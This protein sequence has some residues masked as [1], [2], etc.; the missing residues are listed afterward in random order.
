[1]ESLPY[2]IFFFLGAIVASFAAVVAERLYTGESWL[3][4]RSR[5][6]SCG[7]YL[8]PLDLV[9]VL[10]WL[11]ARGRCR[12][13]KARVPASYAALEALTGLTFALAYHALGPALALMPF[14]GAC[15][16]LAFIVMYD[17]RHTVVPPASSALLVLLSIIH[18]S[19][20]AS[21][22]A[23][24]GTR[25]LVAGV[26]GLGFFLMH[27][28]SKGRAMGLADAPVAFALSLLVAPYA[29]AGLLFSFWSGAVIGIAIL[30][31]RRGGPRMGIEVP[32]VPFLAIGYLLAY[33]V[34][35]NP[36]ALF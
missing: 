11:F 12:T 28:L 31:L 15:A 10:S 29:L 26:I 35:W 7:R 27:A 6:N 14:L 20:V 9:P 16:V 23:Q 4:G 17:L 33:F 2:V 36:L 34:E 19:L 21:S 8:G 18:A 13:C 22:S 5:C 30:F 3:S 32:F 1:M 25:L 24:F